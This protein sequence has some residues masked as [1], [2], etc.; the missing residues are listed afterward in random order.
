MNRD[1][2]TW[3]CART[4][5]KHEHIAA[6]NLTKH[7]GLEV[8]HPRLRMERVTRRGLVRLVEPLFPGYIFLRGLTQDRLDEVRFVTGI[9]SL[10]HFGQQ[11][12]TVPVH[13]IEELRQCFDLNEPLFVEDS[14]SIGAEVTVGEGVLQ[15][16]KGTVVRILPA[17][18]RI[19]ILVEF[20]GRTTITELDRGSVLLENSCVADLMP[21][22]ARPRVGQ[23][24]APQLR[25]SSSQ[26][27]A[28]P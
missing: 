22:L 1:S 13:V 5:P 12:A 9:S 6:G 8:F 14:L 26:R 2:S 10:V 18:Q 3:Y 7:L 24:V 25:S 17:K 16:S 27:S 21:S 23:V 4:K 20:L 11:I 28:I 19:M 15:G